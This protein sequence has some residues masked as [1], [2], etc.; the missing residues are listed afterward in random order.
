MT[1]WTRHDLPADIVVH[2]GVFASQPAAYAAILGACPALDLTHVEVIH[3]PP[4][5]RLAARFEAA[6][7]AAIETAAAPCTTLVLILPAAYAGLDCPLADTPALPRLG[8]WRGRV[9]HLVAE[10]AAT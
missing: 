7:A 8:L 6:T 10:R 1:R 4:R 3:G 9:P 5:L 2:A